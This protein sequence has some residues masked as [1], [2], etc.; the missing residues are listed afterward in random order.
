MP[1]QAPQT[2]GRGL[3][4]QTAPVQP[5]IAPAASQ[6]HD[7][8]QSP[9][10]S[11]ALASTDPADVPALARLSPAARARFAPVLSIDPLLLGALLSLLP[12][13][14][15]LAVAARAGLEVGDLQ[16]D[17]AAADK[18]AAMAVSAA[19]DWSRY[20]TGRVTWSEL[21]RRR[22]PPHGDRSDWVRTGGA[23]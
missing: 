16:R 12:L 4:Q 6:L 13:A 22:Y 19:M 9:T 7:P 15:P 5:K 21:E 17:A 11:A 10:K 20:A 18:E 1:S 2:A 8:R 3:R 14:H 23:A